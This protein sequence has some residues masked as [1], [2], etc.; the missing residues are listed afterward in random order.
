MRRNIHFIPGPHLGLILV[1]SSFKMRILKFF[2]TYSTFLFT[3][4]WGLTRRLLLG[5]FKCLKRTFLAAYSLTSP[6]LLLKPFL[7]RLFTQ[8]NL[9]WFFPFLRT[10]LDIQTTFGL[11]A[12]VLSNTWAQH[13]AREPADVGYSPTKNCWPLLVSSESR[14]PNLFVDCNCQY[15]LATLASSCLEVHQKSNVF[16]NHR[17]TSSVVHIME[18]LHTCNTAFWG[19]KV[20]ICKAVITRLKEEKRKSTCDP[21]KR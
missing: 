8:V 5:L 17:I 16:H 10:C 9:E 6:S 18:Q 20:Q 21:K 11:D 12:F 13:R 3:N 19:K 15:T 2:S 4:F 7:I 1:L 14:F